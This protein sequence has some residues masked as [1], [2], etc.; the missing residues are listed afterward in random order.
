[1][2]SPFSE[3]K[4]STKT[5]IQYN[6]THWSLSSRCGIYV[7]RLLP[8]SRL[9]LHLLGVKVILVKGTLKIKKSFS[10]KMTKVTKF[11]IITQEKQL[12]A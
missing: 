12:K 11:L 10:I 6:S 2:H 7:R 4:L 5:K 1:M 8:V 9:N 3:D